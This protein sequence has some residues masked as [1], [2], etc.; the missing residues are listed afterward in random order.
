MKT[1]FPTL[2]GSF[3]VGY[4]G[5]GCSSPFFYLPYSLTTV[6]F[7]AFSINTVYT[8]PTN[9]FIG[10]IMTDLYMEFQVIDRCN[11]DCSYCNYASRYQLT[12]EIEFDNLTL[13]NIT[14]VSNLINTISQHFRIHM[15]AQG[16]EIGLL[17][18]HKL[19]Q[20][21]NTL[22]QRNITISTNGEFI[23]HNYHNIFAHYIGQVHYH[24]TP[25]VN[26]VN[27][28]LTGNVIPGAVITAYTP[29]VIEQLIALYPLQYLDF[30]LPLTEE[31]TEQQYNAIIACRKYII[32]HH[33]T[34]YDNCPN[35]ILPYQ[36][37]VKYQEGCAKS[38][39][40][41]TIDFTNNCLCLCSV[42][43]RHITLPLTKE[44]LVKLL[45]NFAVYDT[46]NSNCAKCV[47]NCF[48]FDKKEITKLLLVKQQLRRILCQ[49]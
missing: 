9:W 39:R 43:N 1:N 10:E 37:L 49:N 4:K 44:N 29:K 40:I 2:F 14:M 28:V 25:D 7:F 30:E 34:L 42:K 13:Q 32:E 38:G 35:N 36:E 45:T 26:E 22:N 17:P 16:G 20:F 12:R 41:V 6:G 19:E 23:K 46:V 48:S 27:D 21:F 31:L 33:P 11:W 15:L 24:I 18:Q 3:N 47:R 5:G 8:K